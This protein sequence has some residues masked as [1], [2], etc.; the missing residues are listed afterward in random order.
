MKETQRPLEV[1]QIE[2][3]DYQSAWNLQKNIVALRKRDALPDTLLLL[4]HTPVIT[5]GRNAGEKNILHTPN[6]LAQLGFDYVRSD[7]GGDA[8]YHG[9]GQLVAYPI[10]NL[11]P[12]MKDV[13]KF[14]RTLEQV[15][16]DV[17]ADYN[18]IGE[19]LSGA[20]G[21]WLTQ[22]D[23][24]IAAIGARMTRWVT[25]HGIALN[26]NTNLSHFNVIVPCGL[27]DK[28]VTSLQQE[29]EVMID[30]QTVC[31]RFIQLFS[32][33]FNRKVIYKNDIPLHLLESHV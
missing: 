24:K 32:H 8:T 1:Y 2:S 13:P 30:F 16:I 21:V 10:L 33:H 6:S 14:V 9:P 23:R 19:R 12:D 11:S 15:I 3:I 4:Q 5:V 20:P 26:I 29:K 28:A 25:Y 7:R 17:I 18:L 22:P 31:T 27:A